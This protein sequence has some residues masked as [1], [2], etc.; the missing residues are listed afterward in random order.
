MI[1]D[2]LVELIVIILVR[3]IQRCITD[4]DALSTATDV[5][6]PLSDDTDDSIDD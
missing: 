4:D 3:I 2:V 6:E 5:T 1:V